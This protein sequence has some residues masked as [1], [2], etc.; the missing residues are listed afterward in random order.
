M[1]FVNILTV[2][3]LKLH[4]AVKLNEHTI[5]NQILK[6]VIYVIFD[7]INSFTYVHK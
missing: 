7:K 5:E 3:G 1:I 4:F 2:I 6:S